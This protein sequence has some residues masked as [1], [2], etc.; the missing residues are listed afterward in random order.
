MLCKKIGQY[1][2]ISSEMWRDA[3]TWHGVRGYRSM[4]WWCDVTWEHGMMIWHESGTR[5]DLISHG[6]GIWHGRC[7]HQRSRLRR[8]RCWTLST[9]SGLTSSSCQRDLTLTRYVSVYCIRLGILQWYTEVE[10][11]ARSTAKRI[12]WAVAPCY[13]AEESFGTKLRPPLFF[14]ESL[15]M[16]FFNL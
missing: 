6:A 4:A 1:T 10:F 9:C 15:G 11:C 16:W 8:R 7:T 3:G 5:H 14:F 12:S 2:V 13:C